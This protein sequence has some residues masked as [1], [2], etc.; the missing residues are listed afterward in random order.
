MGM[1]GRLRRAVCGC[2]VSDQPRWYWAQ[3]PEEVRAN[4]DGVLEMLHATHGETYLP[5]P[6]GGG[7]FLGRVKRGVE[8]F[9]FSSLYLT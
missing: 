3:Y 2:R 9:D 5:T 6:P 1:S 4:A 8:V 7:S